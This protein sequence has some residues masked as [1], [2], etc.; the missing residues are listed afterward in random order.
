M[1][2][3][4]GVQVVLTVVCFDSDDIATL[5]GNPAHRQNLIDNLLAQVQAGGA[6]G[7][8]VDFEGVPGDQRDNLTAFMADLAQAFH[9][10]IP[11]SQVTMATPPVDWRD[12]FD[13]DALADVCDGLMIM[14]YGY[15]WKGVPT[16]DPYLP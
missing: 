1:A 7:V 11:G 4:N 2:H 15:H 6:D 10:T 12:A 13:Y 8:N 5:L 14:G 3:N 9:T 16:P